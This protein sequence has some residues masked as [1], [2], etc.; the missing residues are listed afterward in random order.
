VPISGAQYPTNWELSTARAATVVRTLVSARVDP[1]RLTAAGRA[2]LDPL[3]TNA[4]H[5]GRS[6]NRRVQIVVPRQAPAAPI[7]EDAE[8]KI[9]PSAP[10]IGPEDSP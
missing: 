6:T 1:R 2:S 5:D 4:T 10:Q 3:S 8:P 9:G 7:T